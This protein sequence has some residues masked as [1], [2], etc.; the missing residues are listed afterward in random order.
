MEAEFKKT[1]VRLPST[2]GD[3]F[4]NFQ[5]ITRLEPALGKFRR[6]NRLAV[7]LH[8]HAARQQIPGD[9]KFLQRT[10][11]LRLNR[12]SIGD[13]ALSTHNLNFAI[14]AVSAASQSFQTG[15]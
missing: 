15:S 13:D 9:E 3:N 14:Q 7:V 10:R 5:T 12:F 6:S 4:N 8:D 11:Q 2:S 1:E